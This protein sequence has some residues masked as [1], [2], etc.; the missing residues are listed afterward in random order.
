METYINGH[1]VDMY[2]LLNTEFWN[3][4]VEGSV[5]NIHHSGLSNDW[6]IAL[7]QVSDQNTQEQ[8]C[9]LLLS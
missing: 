2:P 5:Q 6:P 9:R 1:L 4:D 7:G 8:V 3:K